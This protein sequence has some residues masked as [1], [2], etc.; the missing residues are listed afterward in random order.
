MVGLLLLRWART[1]I[2]AV[3][4]A[5][6]SRVFGVTI[7]VIG[8]LLVC[9]GGYVAAGPSE[10]LT[11]EL[12]SGVSYE[13]FSYETAVVHLVT[14]DLSSPCVA[15]ATSKVA[16]DG[17][18]DALKTITWAD[19]DNMAV[20]IN[21][22]FFFPYEQAQFWNVT[23]E[24]GEE[25]NVLGPTVSGLP[26]AAGGSVSI[27]AIDWDGHTL[28]ITGSGYASIDRTVASNASLAITGRDR[29]IQQ[30]RVVA[31][32]SE[33]YPRTVVGVDETGTTMWWL[34]ADGKQPGYSDGLSLPSAGEILKE[35]GAYDA[36]ELDGG[37]SS[38]LVARTGD[39][40]DAQVERLSRPMQ[41][42]IPGRSRAV[43]NHLGLRVPTAPGC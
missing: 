35:R 27:G 7:V 34:V 6:V 8:G 16:A 23:P 1:R 40:P 4:L 19:N 13:R 11:D 41:I 43:A 25:V 29:L 22:S 26:V 38:I 39:G 3:A 14:I 10:P 37:G 36:V 20:A 28:S 12:L 31:S 17:T 33:P 21:G 15:P 42:R 9:Y 24:E 2:D 30:G 5:R 32:P 18:A